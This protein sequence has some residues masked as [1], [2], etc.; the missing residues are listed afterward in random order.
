MLRLAPDVYKAMIGHCYDGLPDE[1]C[2]LVAAAPGSDKAVVLYPTRNAAESSRV[3][4]VDPRDLLRADRDAEARGLQLAGVFHSH[5]HTDAYPSPTDV[6][7]APDPEWHYVLVSLKDLVP[8][9]RSYRIVDGNI[10]EEPV[11]LEGR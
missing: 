6:A 8:V 10:T 1:A 3:Y 4:E 11:V 2:G 7:Q 9:V 5:T